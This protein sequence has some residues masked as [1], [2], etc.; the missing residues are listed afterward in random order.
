MSP[1]ISLS[2]VWN[3][4][5]DQISSDNCPYELCNYIHSSF[6]Q[7]DFTSDPGAKSHSLVNMPAGDVGGCGHQKCYCQSMSECDCNE[8]CRRQPVSKQS[9]RND[10]GS[11]TQKMKSRV[12]INSAMVAR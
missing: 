6:E 1:Q 11:G 4:H 8:A 5:R 3:N 9:T 7:A 12:A 2:G 10:E